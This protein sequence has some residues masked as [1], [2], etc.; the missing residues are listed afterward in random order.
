MVHED[1]AADS[2]VLKAEVVVPRIAIFRR[3]PSPLRRWSLSRTEQLL[4]AHF[5]TLRGSVNQVAPGE[6]MMG[7]LYDVRASWDAPGHE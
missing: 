6:R 1:D 5:K 7:G 4:G 2:E 3:L